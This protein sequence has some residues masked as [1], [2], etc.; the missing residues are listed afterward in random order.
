MALWVGH[1]RATSGQI[2]PFSCVGKMRLLAALLLVLPLATIS[3]VPSTPSS[4]RSL[5]K[6]VMTTSALP[7]LLFPATAKAD[8][9]EVAVEEF[10]RVTTRMGGLLDKVSGWKESFPSD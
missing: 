8:P 1:H 9:G 4:R 10:D 6:K 7:F 2:L 3:Y 5:V